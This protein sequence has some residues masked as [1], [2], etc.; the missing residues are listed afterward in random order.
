MIPLCAEVLHKGGPPP[1]FV[2]VSRHW[3]SVV[4][5]QNAVARL[6]ETL[7]FNQRV[8]GSNPGGLTSMGRK[9]FS[10]FGP[11]RFRRS[12]VQNFCSRRRCAPSVP[13]TFTP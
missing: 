3:R 8:P 9:G 10:T 12:I 2:S 7:T 11:G 6:G 13:A 1:P 5:R 4:F